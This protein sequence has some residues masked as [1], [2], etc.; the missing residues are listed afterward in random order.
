MSSSWR[1]GF[2][3]RMDREIR[4]PGQNLLMCALSPYNALVCIATGIPNVKY[5]GTSLVLLCL[6]VLTTH[7]AAQTGAADEVRE[8]L[9]AFGQLCRTTTACPGPNSGSLADENGSNWQWRSATAAG[10][11]NEVIQSRWVATDI[12]WPEIAAS[13]AVSADA[14]AVMRFTHLELA[15]GRTSRYGSW[16][17]HWITFRSG[18]LQKSFFAR[19]PSDGRA[20]LLLGRGPGYFIAQAVEDGGDTLLVEMHYRGQGRVAFPFPLRGAASALHRIGLLDDKPVDAVTDGPAENAVAATAETTAPP[21]PERSG[22]EIYRTFCFACHATAVAEAPLF[23]S[24][25]QWQPRIDKGMD[26]L[27]A[28]SFAGFDL[29]PPMG[30]CINCSDDEMRNAIQYMIDSAR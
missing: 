28:T 23:G 17:N 3:T 24:L 25:E 2:P 27:V 14:S 15:A 18:A 12:G 26:T 19:A 7:V 22:E 6:L 13:I 1:A 9:R 10:Q 16:K 8:R 30:T 21:V 11:T 29:M 4:R 5:T 20:V